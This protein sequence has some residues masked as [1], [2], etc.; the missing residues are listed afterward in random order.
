MISQITGLS[1]Y[2]NTETEMFPLETWAEFSSSILQTTNTCESFHSKLNGISFII[3][4]STLY[5]N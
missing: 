1:N 5:T 4:I 3:V 2:T